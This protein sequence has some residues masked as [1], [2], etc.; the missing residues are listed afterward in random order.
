[1]T[2]LNTSTRDFDADSNALMGA[3]N[4]DNDT[5]SR[6]G[7]KVREFANTAQH[8]AGE[9][10]RTQAEHGKT[11]AANALRD[12]AG[13]LMH[14]KEESADVVSKYIR[15]AGDQVQ[16]AADYLENTDVR[17]VMTDVERFARR[18][19]ALFLGGAFML[20]LVAARVLK[21]SRQS[22]GAMGGE[23]WTGSK[24][25]RER[26]FDAF[27][28]PSSNFGGATPV[29]AGGAAFGSAPLGDFDDSQRTHGALEGEENSWTDD[30]AS[31]PSPTNPYANE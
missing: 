1:M 10:V 16:R 20:G 5:T 9:Q 12:V 28:E 29:S 26:S 11:R 2:D 21:S 31:R 27:R 17:D 22:N 19:P 30:T 14:P 13:S 3:T 6:V 7:E 23:Q 8:R 25:D 24:Y 15:T 4:G 18:Q